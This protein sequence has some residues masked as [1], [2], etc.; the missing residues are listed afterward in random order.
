MMKIDRAP[1]FNW[2][3]NSLEPKECDTVI[4]LCV[5]VCNLFVML[6]LVVE[7]FIGF[8]VGLCFGVS[9]L[10]NSRFWWLTLCD[11]LA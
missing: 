1:Y 4:I 7:F 11:F 2:S 6:D 9:L 10:V 3:Y 8:W 5:F